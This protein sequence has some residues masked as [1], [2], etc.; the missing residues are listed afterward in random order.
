LQEQT[1]TTGGGLL[2]EIPNPH[3]FTDEIMYFLIPVFKS[4]TQTQTSDFRPLRAAHTYA[5]LIQ[6]STPLPESHTDGISSN[7]QRIEAW[8]FMSQFGF[9]SVAKKAG[10]VPALS[11]DTGIAWANRERG[12]S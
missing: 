3:P 1:T 6:G 2:L 10:I 4:Q 9:E 12:A 5:E 7:N 8:W 11:P